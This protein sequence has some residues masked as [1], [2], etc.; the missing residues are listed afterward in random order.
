MPVALQDILKR[1]KAKFDS[2]DSDGSGRL[3][4]QEF[5]SAFLGGGSHAGVGS[6]GCCGLACT[7]HPLCCC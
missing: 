3:Q 6:V 7:R 5:I 2:A 1:V 4:P